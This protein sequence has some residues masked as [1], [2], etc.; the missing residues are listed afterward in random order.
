[1]AVK[2]KFA[3]PAARHCCYCQQP[4]HPP[5]VR[6][7]KFS[8]SRN[9]SAAAVLI[10]TAGKSKPIRHTAKSAWTSPR[11]W[12]AQNPGYRRKLDS[13]HQQSSIAHPPISTPLNHEHACP[14][15]AP[16]AAFALRV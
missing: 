12:R 1:M 7:R 2:G 8:A 16:V 11:K 9:A 13:K 14:R 3:L 15:L 5:T 4:F 10:T 6:N